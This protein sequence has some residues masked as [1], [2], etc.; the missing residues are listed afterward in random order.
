L[1]TA[2][3]KPAESA[4]LPHKQQHSSPHSCVSSRMN[5]G[6]QKRQP[7]GP[8]SQL[9]PVGLYRSPLVQL[10]VYNELGQCCQPQAYGQH[11]DHRPE[12]QVHPP[13]YVHEPC[14]GR[15]G[16]AHHPQLEEAS[17]E[18]HPS[19]CGGAIRDGHLQQL[20]RAVSGLHLAAGPQPKFLPDHLTTKCAHDNTGT[21]TAARPA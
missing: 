16:E 11:L 10:S 13:A 15:E 12:S 1:C 8:K 18:K 6:T 21:C 4:W 20:I 5:A 2:A 3:G 14:H 17:K 7:Q 9:G 19:S